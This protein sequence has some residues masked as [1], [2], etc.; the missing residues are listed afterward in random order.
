MCRLCIILTFAIVA[1]GAQ[2]QE[3]EPFHVATFSDSRTVSLAIASSSASADKE[4]DFDIG[5][6]LTEMGSGGISFFVDD[7]A[8]LVRVRCEAPAAVKVGGVVHFVQASL[9]SRDWKQDLWKALCQQPT[10]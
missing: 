9:A 5:V 3:R 6:S 1:S 7:S 8:H 2:A 4:F 10:S